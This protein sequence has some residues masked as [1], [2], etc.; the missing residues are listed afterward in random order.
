[1]TYLVTE[2]GSIPPVRCDISSVNEKKVSKD[3]AESFRKSILC[4]HDNLRC[5]CF[6]S[7][8]TNTKVYCLLSLFKREWKRWHIQFLKLVAVDVI[9]YA[10]CQ[11]WIT[12]SRYVNRLFG[13]RQF[14]PLLVNVTGCNV[15][16][17]MAK[18]YAITS[19][20]ST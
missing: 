11:P 15:T 18:M 10:K 1:M 20:F 6:R 16:C 3:K 12:S 4:V 8:N 2:S 9:Y 19:T 14:C 7:P 13:K 17:Y 5:A